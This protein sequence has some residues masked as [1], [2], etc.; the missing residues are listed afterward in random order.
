[1]AVRDGRPS[2]ELLMATGAMED[3]N[4]ADCL[5]VQVSRPVQK[6]MACTEIATSLSGAQTSLYYAMP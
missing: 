1:M 4:P 6:Y 5:I 2:G 3:D